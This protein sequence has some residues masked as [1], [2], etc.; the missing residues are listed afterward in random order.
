MHKLLKILPFLLLIK[1]SVFALTLTEALEHF[2]ATYPGIQ[3]QY[4]NVRAAENRIDVAR[5]GYR[6]TVYSY[7]EI[8]VARYTRSSDRSVFRTPKAIGIS[9]SQPLYRGGRTIAA[10]KGSK[11]AYLAQEL[12]YEEEMEQQLL[13]TAT[14]YIDVLREQEILKANL[15]NEEYLKKELQVVTDRFKLGDVTRTDLA[16]AKS[17]F[18]GAQAQVI[19]SRGNLTSIKAELERLIS[20][21]VST[22]EFPEFTPNLPK[23]VE[24]FCEKALAQNKE[25]AAQ[26]ARYHAAIQVYREIKG[27]QYPELDLDSWIQHNRDQAIPHEYT[28]EI[29][30]ELSF[31]IPLYQAG[32]V[33]ARMREAAAL[34]QKE[35]LI[36]LEIEKF[37]RQYCVQAWENLETSK[38]QITA[39]KT[40][41]ETAEVALKG[42]QEEE[43]AGMRTILD[44]LNAEFEVLYAK[45]NLID[46]RRDQFVAELEILHL[47]SNLF[48]QFLA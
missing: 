17:R 24:A 29:V 31:T 35:W 10:I 38:F 26:L 22:L 11:Y 9:A 23:N 34:A 46:A 14:L 21:K 30:A 45:V 19:Q 20:Q 44:I 36:Y 5:S 25:L 40:Q 48:T 4:Q 18:A 12:S 13:E 15:N 41:L 32:R 37:I 2:V 43:S 6:P 28:N 47:L 8:G 42:V 1:T 27:E 16:Q 33:K 39:Y 7:G 3:A